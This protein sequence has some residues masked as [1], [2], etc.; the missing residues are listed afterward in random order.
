MNFSDSL[1]KR[2]Y[3][4]CNK[5]YNWFYTL[6][7]SSAKRCVILHLMKEVLANKFGAEIVN[8]LA[9]DVTMDLKADNIPVQEFLFWHMLVG[10]TPKR[11]SFP[12]TIRYD[13][14]NAA[15]ERY[16]E[17]RKT[18]KVVFDTVDNNPPTTDEVIRL[19]LL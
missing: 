7:E 15:L 6:D 18:N 9:C 3:S 4:E 17:I 5:K 8:D 11:P 19:D 14:F 2:G 16:R 12:D 13:V 1:L 10:S